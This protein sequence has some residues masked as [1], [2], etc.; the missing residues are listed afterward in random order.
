LHRYAQE[1]NV[2]AMFKL[3]QMYEKEAFMWLQTAG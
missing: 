2:K 1:Y 3:E